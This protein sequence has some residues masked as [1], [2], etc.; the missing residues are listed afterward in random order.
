VLAHPELPW[1]WYVL[2]IIIPVCDIIAH[3]ELPWRYTGLDRNWTSF[4]TFP[5]RR[6][7]EE[8]VYYELIPELVEAY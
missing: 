8:R 1:D 2:A 3:P 5:D 4:E 6:R 7:E